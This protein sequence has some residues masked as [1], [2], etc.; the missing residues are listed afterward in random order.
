MESP[1]HPNYHKEY[2]PLLCSITKFKQFNGVGRFMGELSE[3]LE[4]ENVA[5]IVESN[6]DKQHMY[7]PEANRQEGQWL[8]NLVFGD[9]TFRGRKPILKINTVGEPRKDNEPI[10]DELRG[11][12]TNFLAF[13]SILDVVSQLAEGGYVVDGVNRPQGNT[14]AE[15]GIYEMMK[16]FKNLQL[17]DLTWPEDSGYFNTVEI[18]GI[19]HPKIPLCRPVGDEGTFYVRVSAPKAHNLPGIS[20]NVKNSQ[21]VMRMAVRCFCEILGP[22]PEKFLDQKLGS[23]FAE[24]YRY[25]D[26][27]DNWLVDVR[28]LHEQHVRDGLPYWNMAQDGQPYRLEMW[29]QRIFDLTAALKKIYGDNMLNVILGPIGRDG[30]GFQ[31]TGKD[32]YFPWH[33][34]SRDA[35]LGDGV[36]ALMTGNED[37]GFLKVGYERGIGIPP[38]K[39]E[40]FLYKGGK[41]EPTS[42]AELKAKR[43]LLEVC[44]FFKYEDRSLRVRH[45][46]EF[47]DANIGEHPEYRQIIESVPN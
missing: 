42:V 5:V 44:P 27:G 30:S 1:I 10:R 18:D 32:V 24:F 13:P 34:I 37:V 20:A 39:A 4:R 12:A 40:L 47:I 33:I 22:P 11:M 17:I 36:L 2:I 35:S 45:S 31:N 9:K 21:G 28:R 41:C 46:R 26:E 15:W 8:A 3:L 23:P 29:S 43:V 6:V 25:A 19:V 7:D 16:P 38:E 14:F